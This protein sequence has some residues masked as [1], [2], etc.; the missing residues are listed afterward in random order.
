MFYKATQRMKIVHPIILIFLYNIGPKDGD[1]LRNFL[2]AFVEKFL[3]RNTIA[4][5]RMEISP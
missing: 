1:S 5:A 3:L 4:G 2:I